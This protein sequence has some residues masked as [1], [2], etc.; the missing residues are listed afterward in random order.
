MP[1]VILLDTSL[2]MSRKISGES[3]LDIAQ[4]GINQFSQLLEKKQPL[5][6]LALL[7]FDTDI[8]ILHDFTKDHNSF[9]SSM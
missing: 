6:K 4:R 9:R 5:E 2:S 1:T 3:H 7:T 8:K